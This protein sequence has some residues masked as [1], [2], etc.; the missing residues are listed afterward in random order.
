MD[1]SASDGQ[2]SHSELRLPDGRR[3]GYA[4]FGK[5]TGI[6]ILLFH[7]SPGSRLDGALLA[8]AAEARGARIIAL[9]RPGTG[10]SDPQ[11]GR[12]LTDW[13]ADVAAVVDYL[14]LRQPALL[15]VSAGAAYVYAVC[16]AMPARVGPVSVVSGVGPP[17]VLTGAKPA[18]MRLLLRRTP[19]FA[20]AMF[21]R[22]AEAAR[23]DPGSFQPPGFNP[24]DREALAPPGVREAYAAAFLEAYR[25]GVGG[26]LQDQSLQLADW[27]FDLRSIRQHVHLWHGEFDHVV[28]VEVARRVAASLPDA[29]LTVVPGAGHLSTL[30]DQASAIL[31]DLLGRSAGPH[32]PP[33]RDREPLRA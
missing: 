6:S 1:G 22:V 24:A 33:D 7:G 11:P 9:D 14:D 17:S 28:P 3:L 16:S 32:V 21:N 31:T 25:S 30:L 23:S 19:A 29:T 13:P 20:A 18:L 27:P 4:I 15:G 2:M 10:L 5:P 26:I 12:R 8:Q